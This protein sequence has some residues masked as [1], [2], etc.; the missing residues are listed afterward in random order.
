MGMKKYK[1]KLGRV[2]ALGNRILT[3]CQQ[4]VLAVLIDP[5]YFK[6]TNRKK[7]KAAGCS[8]YQFYKIMRDP[9]FHEYVHRGLMEM[10]HG[11]AG[12]I[13]QTAI[14]SAQ[15]EGRD[16]FPDRRMILEMLNFYKPKQQV[17]MNTRH[18][19]E[20]TVKHEFDQ[21]K[22]K[23]LYKRRTGFADRNRD[24]AETATEN[25]LTQSVHTDSTN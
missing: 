10:L 25:R 6:L 24:G 2:D 16:G 7:I 9:T 8:V 17:D 12:P 4:K 21:E 3:T 22:F 23:E 19:G 18:D 1:A 13:M 11:E 15:I 20:V 5:K 14:R